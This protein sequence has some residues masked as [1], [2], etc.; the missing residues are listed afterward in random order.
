VDSIPECY[1]ALGVVHGLWPYIQGEFDDYVAT[2]K[3]N[4]YRSIHTAV[5]GPQGKSVEVQ[6]RTREMHE[7]RRR[8]ASP[9]TGPTRKAEHVTRNT[10]ARSNGYDGFSSHMTTANS[11]GEADSERDFLERV[12]TELFEDRITHSPQRVR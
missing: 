3:D 4:F 6:I 1:A 12:R 10:N 8:S 11:G 2:P 9:P 5:L 7:H